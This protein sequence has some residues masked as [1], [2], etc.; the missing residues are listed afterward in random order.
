[1]MTPTRGVTPTSR[2]VIDEG[3]RDKLQSAVANVTPTGVLAK[4]HRKKAEPGSAKN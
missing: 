3:K 1:L 2:M 4:Q